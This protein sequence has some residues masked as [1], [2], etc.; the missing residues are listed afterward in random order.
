MKSTHSGKYAT[1]LVPKNK[2]TIRDAVNWVNNNNFKTTKIDISDNYYRFR[3][4]VPRN[5]ARYYSKK[6]RN[7]IVLV[8][9]RKE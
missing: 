9:Y 6:L 1:V 2:F 5:Y 3:Q 7:G 4:S 8:M